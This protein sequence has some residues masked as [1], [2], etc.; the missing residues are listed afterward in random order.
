MDAANLGGGVSASPDLVCKCP[1]AAAFSC[2]DYQ[3]T[4]CSGY[5]D[6][7]IYVRVAVQKPFQTLA[8]YIKMPSQVA[9]NE[10][11]MMRVR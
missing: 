5:G 1:G 10:T 7:R 8:N 2:G 4:T 3:T 9:I 6:A 11:T